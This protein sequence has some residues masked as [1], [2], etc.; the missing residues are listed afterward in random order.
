MKNMDEIY[1]EWSGKHHTENS[2]H[3]VHD[4]AEAM[5]FAQYYH[6]EQIE[7]RIDKSKATRELKNRAGKIFGYGS[8]VSEELRDAYMWGVKDLFDYIQGKQKE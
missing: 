3:P 1:K 8:W 4:S 5:D 7:K 2:C 6:N